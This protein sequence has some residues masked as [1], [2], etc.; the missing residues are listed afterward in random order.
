M[1]GGKKSWEEKQNT[2]QEKEWERMKE[3][4]GEKMKHNG[5]DGRRKNEFG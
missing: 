1:V 3:Q 5:A 4:A 2:K